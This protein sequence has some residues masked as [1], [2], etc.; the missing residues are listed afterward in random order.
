MNYASSTINTS[1]SENTSCNE[2][3]YFS[4]NTS[5]NEN[6]SFKVLDLRKYYLRFCSTVSIVSQLV[7]G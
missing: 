2:N 3:T 4:E 7:A 6:A 1:C 5:G